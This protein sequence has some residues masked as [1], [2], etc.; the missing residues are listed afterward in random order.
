ME[1][2]RTKTAAQFHI[3]IEGASLKDSELDHLTERFDILL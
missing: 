3:L 2:N 1:L